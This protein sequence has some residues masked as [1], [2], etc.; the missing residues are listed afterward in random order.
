MKA[1]SPRLSVRLAQS[2]KDVQAAQHLRYQIFVEE[3]GAQATRAEHASKME[4]DEFDPYF[5]H[6]LLIDETEGE[7]VGAYR[8]MRGST[9][10]NGI[11]FYGAGEYDLT[12]LQNLK[13]ETLELGRSCVA[14]P[15]RGGMGMHKLWNALGDYVITH[16]IGVLFGVASFHNAN[17]EPIAE[18]LSY[19]YHNH[20]APPELRVRARQFTDMN[21]IPAEAVEKRTALKQIPSLI[22][23]YLRLGGF[24][25]EGAFIDKDFNTV[26]V[27]LIMDTDNMVQKYRAFYSRNRT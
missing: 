20:L 27:C 19:L 2:P 9:A 7:V 11:G 21:R 18:A 25:G 23:A 4:V 17:P 24:V 10:R 8:L 26:D 3:M 13:R 12:K 1:N 15:Y 5:E 6:L 22:K 14:A 16:D